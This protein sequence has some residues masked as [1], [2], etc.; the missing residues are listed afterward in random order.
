MPKRHIENLDNMQD[1]ELKDMAEIMNKALLKLKE[2]NAPYNYYFHYSPI[3]EKLHF[4]IEITPRLSRWAGYE[5]ST[6]TI[7][8]SIPPEDAAKFYRGEEVN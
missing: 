3:G 2:I 1:F 7:I 4:H 8:N 6:G 5:F